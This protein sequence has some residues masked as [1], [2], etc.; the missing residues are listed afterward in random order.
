MRRS[1][2]QPSAHRCGD[3]ASSPPPSGSASRSADSGPRLPSTSRASGSA[4]LDGPRPG[5]AP[6]R[7]RARRTP[8]RFASSLKRSSIS[9]GADVVPALTSHSGR[10][11]RTRSLNPAATDLPAGATWTEGLRCDCRRHAMKV[12]SRKQQL[13]GHFSLTGVELARTLPS[14][15]LVDAGHR[16][17]GRARRHASSQAN[18]SACPASR[19]L[20]TKAEERQRVVDPPW[21][22]L[23]DC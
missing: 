13:R 1:L 9:H 4:R 15:A 11:P 5:R 10:R 17:L 7:W 6:G 16:L 21:R 3:E 22:A 14:D 12:V 8:R 23:R 19:A 2:R 18:E 20:Q